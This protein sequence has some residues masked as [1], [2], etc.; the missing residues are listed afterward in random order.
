VNGTKE[1]EG[2]DGIHAKGKGEHQSDTKGWTHGGQDP[3][4]QADKIPHQQEEQIHRL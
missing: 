1:D 2:G 3:D 4:D